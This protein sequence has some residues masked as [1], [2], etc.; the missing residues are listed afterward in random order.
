[1]KWVIALF[2]VIFLT[3][4]SSEAE[5]AG[6]AKADVSEEVKLA[7]EELAET[8]DKLAEVKNELSSQESKLEELQ[9][10]SARED[11]MKQNIKDYEID[12]E[13]WE[14]KAKEAEDQFNT[15]SGQVED[16]EGEPV[17]LGAGYYYFGSDVEPGRYKL[18]AQEGQSGNV[19][20]RGLDGMSK[21]AD[22]FGQGSDYVQE[23][24]FEGLE[25]EEIEATVPVVLTP[26]E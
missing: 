3:A 19:F 18:S 21:V 24:V 6:P 26:V 9:E 13:Y 14:S 5:Q 10:L 1:M 12:V 2:S 15:I 22:T 4:C 16:A 11:E 8:E 23:F 7:Q 17:E 25:G 20:V